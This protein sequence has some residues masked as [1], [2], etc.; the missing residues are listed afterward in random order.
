LIGFNDLG[1]KGN[2]GN[3][4]FQYA[5][6]RGIAANRGFNWQIPP[7]DITRIHDYSLF[8][9]FELTSLKS[10]N[11]GY[12]PF[13]T[14]ILNSE[15]DG[16]S[17]PF[18]FDSYL[19]NNCPDNVNL[20]GFFQSE[21]YFKNIA[22]QIREDLKFKESFIQ[23]ERDKI[24]STEPTFIAV[25]IRRGDYLKFPDHHPILA[26]E[27]YHQALERLP[28]L[29]LIV[30]TNDK[31][32]VPYAKFLRN[33]SYEVAN[34]EDY[35]HDL[36]LMTKASAFVVANSSFSWWGAWLSDADTVIAPHAWFGPKL[37]HLDT[38]DLYPEAWV[39]I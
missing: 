34:F 2:L 12:S 28:D 21:K 39:L 23:I 3:Q 4:I 6:L 20:N 33:K 22:F 14:L 17:S 37:Q 26:E 38:S 15:H 24:A 25:H 7:N 27:Y 36:Y 8:R 10:D 18:H 11:I 32:W 29:P 35:G 9:L 1:R 5:A 19:F 30:F 13:E 31:S 16:N